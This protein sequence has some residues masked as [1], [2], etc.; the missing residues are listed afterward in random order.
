[1]EKKVLI[2]DEVNEKIISFEEFQIS[3]IPKGYEY[4]AIELKDESGKPTGL[5]FFNRFLFL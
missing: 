3:D 5:F 2:S 1:M 4:P